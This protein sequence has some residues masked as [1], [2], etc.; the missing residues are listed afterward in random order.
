MITTNALDSITI[1]RARD[2]KRMAK[3][4]RADGTIE[5]YDCAYTSI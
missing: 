2:G 3:L 5:D 1:I 4:I